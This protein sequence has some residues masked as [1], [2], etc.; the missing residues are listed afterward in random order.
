MLKNEFTRSLL[1]SILLYGVVQANTLSLLLVPLY[2]VLMWSSKFSFESIFNRN[3]F[4]QTYFFWL[5]NPHL[6]FVAVH[7]FVI[8]KWNLSVFLFIWL[9]KNHWNSLFADSLHK[10]WSFPLQS[11][12]N[13]YFILANLLSSWSWDSALPVSRVVIR[14]LQYLQLSFFITK[15]WRW[16]EETRP[17]RR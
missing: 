1:F 7:Q 11:L 5:K 2:M 15:A 8:I 6:E 10:K 9:S 17:K 3:N 16:A 12:S 4:S 13:L 14:L